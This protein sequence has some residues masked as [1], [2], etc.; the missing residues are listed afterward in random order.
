VR[1]SSWSREVLFT[2]GERRQ[3]EALLARGQRHRAFYHGAG[4]FGRVDDLER[5]LIDQ[6]V[7]ER[8]EADTIFLF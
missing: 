5:R 3:I 8:L 7:F 4:A 1:I 2:C 6:P